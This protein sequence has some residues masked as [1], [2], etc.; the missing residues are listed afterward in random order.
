MTETIVKLS[1]HSRK[2]DRRKLMRDADIVIDQHGMVIKDRNGVGNR[3]ATAKELS[4]AVK[5]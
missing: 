1:G 4:Q 3:Q 5:K 2:S